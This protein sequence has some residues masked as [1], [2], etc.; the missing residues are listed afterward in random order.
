MRDT[1][2]N[3]AKKCSEFWY[4]GIIKESGQNNSSESLE[5]RDGW[6]QSFGIFG[7]LSQRYRVIYPSAFMSHAIT[8][9]NFIQYPCCDEI[10]HTQYECSN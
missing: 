7:I 1:A 9:Q 2:K 10:E 3:R 4:Q 6:T 8:I 5:S